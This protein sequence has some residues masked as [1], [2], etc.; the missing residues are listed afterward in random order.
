MIE[1][2]EA[3]DHRQAQRNRSMRVSSPSATTSTP[4][5]LAMGSMIEPAVIP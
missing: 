4:A 5:P 2:H 3:P 1:R